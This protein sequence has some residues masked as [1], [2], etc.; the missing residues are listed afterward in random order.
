MIKRVQTV[1]AVECFCPPFANM[2]CLPYFS[3]NEKLKK[4]DPTPGYRRKLV[5]ILQRREAEN[6][7]NESQYKLLCPTVEVTPA[8]YCT[9]KDP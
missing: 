1:V 4:E 7:I 2:N 8:L 9:K 5:N 6:K 3:S